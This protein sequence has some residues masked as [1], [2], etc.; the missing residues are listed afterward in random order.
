MA[1]PLFNLLALSPPKSLIL[2]P[3]V[4][5]PSVFNLLFVQQSSVQP[6][7]ATEL[8]NM[9]ERMHWVTDSEAKH[10]IG[11]ATKGYKDA[12]AP[13]STIGQNRDQGSNAHRQVRHALD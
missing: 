11:T 8:W 3:P 2:Y 13:L 9:W 7:P 10:I 12:S 5:Q 6:S 4:G 1:Q